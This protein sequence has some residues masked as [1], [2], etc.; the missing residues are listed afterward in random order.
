MQFESVQKCD[1]SNISN[2]DKVK[3]CLCNNNPCA[4]QNM[5]FKCKTCGIWIARDVIM[6]RQFAPFF[7][8]MNPLNSQQPPQCKTTG[9]SY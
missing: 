2:F 6:N 8:T 9:F 5:Y 1:H 7:D 4:C 3:S